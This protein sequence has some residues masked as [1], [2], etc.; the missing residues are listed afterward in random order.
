ME[1]TLKIEN[2]SGL[3]A[4]PAALF[5]KEASAFK[6]TIMILKG[7]KNV[8]AKSIISIMGLGIKQG[9]SL[10]FKIEGADAEEAAVALKKLV[11]NN[12]GEE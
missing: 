2:K 10:L 12:F 5:A 9:E 1:L 3:H 7:D 6:S 11:S 8:N 4:R